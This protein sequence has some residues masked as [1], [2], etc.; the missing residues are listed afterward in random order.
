MCSFGNPRYLTIQA[1]FSSSSGLFWKT[2]T[3][4]QGQNSKLLLHVPLLGSGTWMVSREPTGHN[5][6]L[7]GLVH[8][9]TGQ[10]MQFVPHFTPHPGLNPRVWMAAP[11]AYPAFSKTPTLLSL[12][13]SWP[14]R[15]LVG[16]RSE[17]ATTCQ[18]PIPNK[19]QWLSRA[20]W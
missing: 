13:P 9:S 6:Q 16:L 4:H 5:S 2:G 1:D 17:T 15:H 20:S 7:P 10:H 11:W 8:L 14:L 12:F 19:G 18:V 3:P